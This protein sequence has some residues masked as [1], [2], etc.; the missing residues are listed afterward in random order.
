MILSWLCGRSD[1]CCWRQVFSSLNDDSSNVVK[2]KILCR[3]TGKWVP[4]TEV[5]KYGVREVL[6][7]KQ[8][9]VQEPAC[10]VCRGVT[11][12]GVGMEQ[13]RQ[14]GGAGQPEGHTSLRSKF[15]K[16]ILM[17]ALHR[18]REAVCLCLCLFS[19]SKHTSHWVLLLSFPSHFF[20]CLSLVLNTF[21]YPPVL[22]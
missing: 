1:F 2:W 3:E 17:H 18:P 20:S 22:S 13:Q 14:G 12:C 4:G 11:K 8:L 19:R 5:L 9:S 6:K 10:C 15:W 7:K 16:N 21:G